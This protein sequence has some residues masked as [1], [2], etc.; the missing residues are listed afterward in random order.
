MTFTSPYYFFFLLSVYVVVHVSPDRLRW[1]VLLVASY[2]FYA[3]FESP[4][5]PAVLALVTV[6]SYAC[7]IR[8]GRAAD[9]RRRIWIF[10][11]GVAAC[12]LILALIKYLPAVAAAFGGE[13]GRP[14]ATPLISVGVS[15][16]TFQAISYLADIYL[17]TQE[18]EMHPGYHALS[19]DFFP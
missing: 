3:T 12:V 9:P 15:Y 17:E 10:R 8:I 4:L 7:G 1:V 14:Y 18:P 16:F 5:L 19:L 11:L 6:I 2:L 13:A